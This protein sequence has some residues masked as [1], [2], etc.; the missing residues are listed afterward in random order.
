MS[1]HTNNT[2]FS[3]LE[4][5]KR[6]GISIREVELLAKSGELVRAVS[7]VFRVPAIT[8]ESFYMY[9]NKKGLNDA[10]KKMD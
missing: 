10:R 7:P 5:S 8:R 1:R 6:L 9:V 3:F 2:V 4:V